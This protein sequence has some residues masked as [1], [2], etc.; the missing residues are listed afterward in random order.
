MKPRTGQ[1]WM[2]PETPDSDLPRVELIGGH[3]VLVGPMTEEGDPIAIGGRCIDCGGGVDR[4]VSSPDPTGAH[5]LRCRCGAPL[6]LAPPDAEPAAGLGFRRLPV[7][8]VDA[9]AFV[10]LPD[11]PHGADV[12]PATQ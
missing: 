2:L 9:D 1:W 4:V 12:A 3:T 10:L 7:V 11:E 5:A 6:D 8:I